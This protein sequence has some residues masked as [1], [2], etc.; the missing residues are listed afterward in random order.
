MMRSWRVGILLLGLVAAIAAI[1][2]PVA[3]DR[4]EPGF[5]SADCPVQHPGHG[6]AIVTPLRPAAP[7][8]TLAFSEP[9][10]RA[11]EGAPSALAS[12]SA[13]RAPPFP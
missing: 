3:E 11:P 4:V 2:P 13:P 1:V 10:G 5:C 8:P 12:P 9:I 6:V 7:R